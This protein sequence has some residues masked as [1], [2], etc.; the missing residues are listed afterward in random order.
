MN[1]DKFMDNLELQNIGTTLK[2]VSSSFQE[3]I[4]CHIF[5]ELN[6][7]VDHFSKEA[8]NIKENMLSLDF[9]DGE[10]N[11][12]KDLNLYEL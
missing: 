7:F 10:L 11:S 5:R 4:F 2:V 12:H 9:S 1:D 6:A 8:I 3:I